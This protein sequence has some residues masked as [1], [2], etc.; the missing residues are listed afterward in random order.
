MVDV[1][2]NQHLLC[3]LTFTHSLT[4]TI[5]HPISLTLLTL[6]HSIGTVSLLEV[7][8]NLA[9]PLTHS[10]NPYPLSPTSLTPNS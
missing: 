1:T 9:T 7:C 2:G 10:F 5:N 6:T 8:D 3:C 4:L